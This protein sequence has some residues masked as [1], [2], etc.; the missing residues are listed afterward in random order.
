MSDEKKFEPKGNIQP[1]PAPHVVY[2]TPSCKPY[3]GVRVIFRQAEGLL[4]RGYRV[5]VVGPDPAPDWYPQKVVY[6]QT[7]IEEPGM[8][9][10]AD[11][12]IGTFWTTIAPAWASSAKY[13][14]HLCQGLENLRPEYEAIYEQIDTVY[15]LPIPKIV[16]SPHLRQEI[17][18]RY[19]CRCYVIGEAVDNTLFFPGSFHVENRP[20]RI[21][22]VGPYGV[23]S[24]GV[25]DALCGLLLA[26]QAGYAIEVYRASID[27]L[28]EREARLGVTDQFFHNLDTAGMV[29][30]YHELDA[31]VHPAHEGG[32]GFPLPSLEAMACG[33]P[34]ALADIRPFAALPDD[35]VIRF[36]P[37]KPEAI[38]PVV[39][40]LLE[41]EKRWALRE[42][43]LACIRAHYTPEKVLDRLEAAFRAEGAPVMER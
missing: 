27:P 33:V 18:K 3:G 17:A 15:R 24:K 2:I 1:E 41:P 23:P 35:A 14:F 20:L 39:A 25:P 9:P 19:N 5:T 43:G 31:C 42:A 4:K 38:V 36:P 7:E 40:A 21:G 8:I 28:D 12:C 16:V 10:T 30:F 37:G 11:I 34:V 32:E 13:I 29:R 6:I 26:R 22:V